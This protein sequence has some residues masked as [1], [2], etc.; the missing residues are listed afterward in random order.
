MGV[1]FNHQLEVNV[2]KWRQVFILQLSR[3]G[4]YE[5]VTGHDKV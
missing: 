4:T 1:V 2:V 3:V 5:I